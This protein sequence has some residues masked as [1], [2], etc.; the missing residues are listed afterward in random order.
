MITET[1]KTWKPR[2]SSTPS[3]NSGI[4]LAVSRS[5]QNSAIGTLDSATLGLLVLRLHSDR[6]LAPG[7]DGDVVVSGP[8][9]DVRGQG[10]TILRAHP[11][12]GEERLQDGVQL[13]PTLRAEVEGVLRPLDRDAHGAN[14]SFGAV[15]VV[16]ED[17]LGSH[18]LASRVLVRCE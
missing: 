12:L 7:G 4:R 5:V 18:G 3:L 10:L 9:T 15:D 14:V 11:G 17:G 8:R 13:T 16:H 1:S 6:D 2:M